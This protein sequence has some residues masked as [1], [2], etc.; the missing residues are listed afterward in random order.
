MRRHAGG[1][2]LPMLNLDP[3]IHRSYKPVCPLCNGTVDRVPRTLLDRALSFF[4]PRGQ[5]LYR[6]QCW[7]PNCAWQGNLK[8]RAARRDVYGADGSRRH[9][10]VPAQMLDAAK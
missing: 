9:V 2:L 3:P 10:L 8:R 7:V 1:K 4:L 5:A 6:Y